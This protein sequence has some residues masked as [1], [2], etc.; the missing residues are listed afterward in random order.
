MC[1]I[2]KL[3]KILSKAGLNLL[4]IGNMLYT[5]HVTHISNILLFLTHERDSFVFSS[6]LLVLEAP[7]S[8]FYNAYII[9]IFLFYQLKHKMSN[10][11]SLNNNRFPLARARIQLTSEDPL[12][13]QILT[14]YRYIA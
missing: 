10:I 13:D 8:T 11:K 3:I 14:T 5:K 9:I 6:R 4:L 7:T 2:C 12:K 1:I